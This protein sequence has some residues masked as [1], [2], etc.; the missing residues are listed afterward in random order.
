MAPRLKLVTTIGV[1][2]CAV[3]FGVGVG[4]CVGDS[5]ST[6]DGGGGDAAGD[7]TLD[8]PNKDG[9]VDASADACAK[10]CDGGCVSPDDPAFG[11]GASTC[12]ACPALAHVTQAAC[13]NGACAIGACDPTYDDLDRDASDGCEIPNPFAYQPSSLKLWLK[14][15]VGLTIVDGGVTS[16]QN[17]APS[18]DGG[19]GAT[20]VSGHPVVDTASWTQLPGMKSVSFASGDNFDADFGGMVG[21][22]YTT[23]VAAARY[24]DQ[25]NCLMASKG[26]PG[27]NPNCPTQEGLAFQMCYGPNT[28]F[29]AEVYCNNLSV[30]APANT[31]SGYQPAVLAM[32]W[33]GSLNYGSINGAV[34]D[35]TG[36]DPSKLS[37]SYINPGRLG[38][39]YA[40]APYTGLIGEVIVYSTLLS[41]PDHAAVQT[42]LKTKWRT[43]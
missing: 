3:C 17:L 4:A 39:G 22:T 6:V 29:N 25:T 42:Y 33:D 21:G 11:C 8:A 15:D 1:V 9:G 43:P 13:S 20:L 41:A 26:S 37:G 40:G 30:A 16:W 36:E 24:G 35:D 27:G 14:A 32:W 7:S 28:V 18:A 31:S 23:F 34:R 2:L 12:S 19:V 38:G 10:T 5:T